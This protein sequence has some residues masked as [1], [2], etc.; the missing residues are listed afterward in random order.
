VRRFPESRP[1]AVLLPAGT[2]HRLRGEACG[3]WGSRAVDPEHGP[4]AWVLV[5]RQ[6][7]VGEPYGGVRV[8]WSDPG[9]ATAQ[10]LEVGWD[11]DRGGSDGAVLGALNALLGWPLL[12]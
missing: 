11:A 5:W 3:R 6:T 9:P 1:L 10:V 7:H 4:E 12:R 8:R 2:A